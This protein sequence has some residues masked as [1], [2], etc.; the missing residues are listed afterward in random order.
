MGHSK[1]QI[2]NNLTKTIDKKDKDKQQLQNK[3]FLRTW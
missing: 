3:L 1:L 2:K